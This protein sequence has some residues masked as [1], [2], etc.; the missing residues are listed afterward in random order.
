MGNSR[1]GITRLTDGILASNC[2]SARVNPKSETISLRH[3]GRPLPWNEHDIV[4][5]QL[6]DLLLRLITDPLANGEQPDDASHTDED[7]QH[8]ERGAHGMQ[9]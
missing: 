2:W 3:P 6:F 4:G 8:R 7:P 1:T 9:Q 5:S